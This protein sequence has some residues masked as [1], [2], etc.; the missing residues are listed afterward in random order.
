MRDFFA[1]FQVKLKASFAGQRQDKKSAESE[2]SEKK[3]FEATND[4]EQRRFDS[5]GNFSPYI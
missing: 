2:N 5:R 4:W 1:R 3:E